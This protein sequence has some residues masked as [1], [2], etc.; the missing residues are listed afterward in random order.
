MECLTLKEFLSI[1]L[2]MSVTSF[3]IG[4]LTSNIINNID[5]SADDLDENV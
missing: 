4:F 3:F 1:T 2:I 5:K